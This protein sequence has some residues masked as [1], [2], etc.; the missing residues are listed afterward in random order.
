MGPVNCRDG[1]LE[2]IDESNDTEVI[3]TVIACKGICDTVMRKVGKGH[4]MTVAQPK[5][6]GAYMQEIRLNNRSRVMHQI[7]EFSDINPASIDLLD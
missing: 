3:P 7:C 6:R 4:A 2:G 1:S 5:D